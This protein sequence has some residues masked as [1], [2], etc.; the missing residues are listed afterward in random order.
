METIDDRRTELRALV[1]RMKSNTVLDTQEAVFKVF[2][3]VAVICE[4]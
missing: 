3:K 2:A 4:Y 1:D